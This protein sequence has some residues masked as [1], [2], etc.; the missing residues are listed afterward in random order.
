[1]KFNEQIAAN[2]AAFRQAIEKRNQKKKRYRSKKKRSRKHH[3]RTTKSRKHL[4]SD[5][6]WSNQ[7]AARSFQIDPKTYQAPNKLSQP[8][9]EQESIIRKVIKD[10][11]LI[12]DGPGPQQDAIVHAFEP[13]Q[14]KGGQELS[15][16]EIEDYFFIVEEG[17]VDIKKKGKVLV[18]AKA[19]GTF[20][21]TNLMYRK[22]IGRK[23]EDGE[24]EGQTLVAHK[25]AKLLRLKR[26]DF[27]GLVQY[28]AKLEDIDKQETLRT[29]PF[30]NKLLRARDLGQTNK[31][32]TADPIDRIASV[33]KPLYFKKG[34]E[35]FDKED[36]T[37]YVIK[38]GNIRLTS[39]KD[40]QFVL[41]PGDYI[42]RQA[43][44]GARGKE[45]EVKSLYALS[46]GMT[47]VIPKSVADKVLGTNFV[48]R[49]TSR[50]DD[51]QKLD[52][53]QCIKSVNLDPKTLSALVESVDDKTFQPGFTLME[54]GSQ[55]EPCLY[56]V[57]EGSVTLFS[58]DGAFVREVGPGG[59]FGVEK[60]LI[61]KNVTGDKA[62]PSKD[63]KLPAQWNVR[64]NGEQ[65][66]VGVLSLL[67]SQEI[68]DNNGQLKE[69]QLVTGPESQMI[70]KR[71]QTSTFVR[72]KVDLDDLEMVT[73][74]GEGAFGQVWLVEADVD[75][76]REQFALKKVEK[77]QDLIDALDREIKFL[78]SFGSHPFMVNLIKVFDRDDSKYMLMSFAAGGE[79]W[80]IVHREDADG[81]W[82]SG[83]PEKQAR[84]YTFLLADT[85][86]YIHS[87]K[88]VYR[89]LKMENI[90]VDS[91]GYPILIDFGFAK[92][93]PDKTVSQ[94]DTR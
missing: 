65:C 8:S 49:Q 60:L 28:Q 71:K 34:N 18:T 79:L 58:D 44:M 75:G 81:N 83:I 27:L 73:V 14:V 36:D 93:C 66:V 89:D 57:R 33:M 11:V 7:M 69:K 15:G 30:M 72:S 91:D 78:S 31:K 53:F 39:S 70:V 42:G 38:E 55:V 20:G 47:Y 17:E 74:L 43:L 48:N 51:Q 12:K 32:R 80:D 59:Y 29:L 35:L 21:D 13:V 92:Y 9:T 68:L 90:L 16:E 37:L 26:E 2:E 40:Q 64:V 22:D 41:G 56:L 24:D 63:M 23:T 25:D 52:N 76:R 5:S 85:L 50:L 86:A 4:S 1:M 87:K 84:F 61:P 62:K 6:V 94:D 46:D 19:G 82:S 54:Q 67:D 10:N 3:P 45:P 88:Y 77:E